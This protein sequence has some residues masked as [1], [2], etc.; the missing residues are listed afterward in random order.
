MSTAAFI[1]VLVCVLGVTKILSKWLVL[2]PH[3]VSVTPDNPLKLNNHVS[4]RSAAPVLYCLQFKSGAS[5]LKLF[6]VSTDMDSD[7]FL[8]EITGCLSTSALIGELVGVF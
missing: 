1:S 4:D 7:F 3:N 6:L 2:L 5:Y 8:T